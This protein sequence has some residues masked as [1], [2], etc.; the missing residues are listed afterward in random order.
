MECKRGQLTLVE[1]VLR[2]LR[3][4]AM[5][6]AGGG[7]NMARQDW[8]LMALAR[9][10]GAPINPV[11]IQ[12]AM[13][14]LDRE[15]AN[16]VRP[17]FYHFRPYNYG[18]FDA[19]IYHDLEDMERRGLIVIS[20]SGRNRRAFASTPDGLKQGC[21]L[22]ERLD[23]PARDYLERVVDWVCSLDFASLVR[24]IYALYPEFKQNSIFAG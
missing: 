10:G 20:G 16:R 1:F 7:E 4:G 21:Q 24:S 2:F 9:R 3:P 6:R 5:G 19:T 13:F 17:D 14:L 11:Q 12:K 22:L 18:P 8:L 15:M 23:S